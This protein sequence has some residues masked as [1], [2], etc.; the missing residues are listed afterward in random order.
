MRY[1]IIIEKT[2]DDTYGAYA[3]DLP[4]VGVTGT[5][6]GEVRQLLKEAITFHLEGLEADGL[7]IPQPSIEIDY[8]ETP[9]A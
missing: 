5:T 6:P 4:G 1:A 2:N 7:P 8:V 3:P 9:A